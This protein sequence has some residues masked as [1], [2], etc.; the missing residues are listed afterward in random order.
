M[1]R[2]RGIR[3]ILF[4][5]PFSLERPRS[6]LS[7]GLTAK[8]PSAFMSQALSPSA[9]PLS[10]GIS[11]PSLSTFKSRSKRLRGRIAWGRIDACLDFRFIGGFNRLSIAVEDQNGAPALLQSNLSTIRTNSLRWKKQYR[12]FSRLCHS[13]NAMPPMRLRMKLK[14]RRR[15]WYAYW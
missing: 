8:P 3:A 6:I 14:L 15:K 13:K 11:L 2:W 5:S 12:E 1:S 9:P 7:P 4:Y 10:A